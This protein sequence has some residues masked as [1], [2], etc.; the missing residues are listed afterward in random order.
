MRAI[1]FTM[2]AGC[3]IPPSLSVGKQDAGVNSPPAILSVH[4]EQQ[5]LPEFSLVTFAV[6]PAAGTA[7]LDLLDT[8]VND[9][10]YVGFFVDYSP[11]SN[12]T[13]ARSNCVAPVTGTPLRTATCDL[14]ALCLPGDV[15]QTRRLNVVVFDRQPLDS[16]SPAFMNLPADGLLTDRSYQL[17]CQ[18]Q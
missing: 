4:S 12:P 15:N 11:T 18:S 16:G 13:P 10:L 6:G 5:E 7:T 8:D 3:V 2:L 1:A 17:T 14:T 9:G